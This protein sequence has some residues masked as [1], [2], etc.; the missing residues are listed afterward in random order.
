[1]KPHWHWDIAHIP[2]SNIVGLP[3]TPS[4]GRV[5]LCHSAA[6][7][8]HCPFLEWMKFLYY[9]WTNSISVTLMTSPCPQLHTKCFCVGGSKLLLSHGTVYKCKFHGPDQSQKCIT[10]VKAYWCLVRQAF[11]GQHLFNTSQAHDYFMLYLFLCQ[12]GRTPASL[13]HIAYF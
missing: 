10:D 7:S 2:H 12:W 1:M 8:A 13:G 5:R 4:R 9:L 6:S 11:A 3:S